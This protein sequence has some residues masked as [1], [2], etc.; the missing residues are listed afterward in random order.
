MIRVKMYPDL[1]NFDK[2]ESGIRRVV[3]A[4]HKYSATYGIRYVGEGKSYDLVAIHAGMY[5]NYDGSR[6][7]VSHCHGLYWTSDYTASAWE[8]RANANVVWSLRYATAISVP[9]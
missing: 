7:L 1:S 8:W 2:Y 9:S 4:Y 5:T 6:P 3:E